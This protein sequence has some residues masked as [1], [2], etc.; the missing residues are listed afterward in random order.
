MAGQGG[1]AP[2]LQPALTDAEADAVYALLVEHCGAY[3]REGSREMFVYHATRG[4]RE[5]RFMGALGFGG[6]FYN[7]G[8]T[9]RVGCY[10]E[11]MTADRAE[12]IDRA[13]VAL[14]KLYDETRGN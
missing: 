8:R 9:W 4:C 12:R 1:I 10:P 3:D 7:D 2:M 5:Y 6:K 14:A 11:D 13:N